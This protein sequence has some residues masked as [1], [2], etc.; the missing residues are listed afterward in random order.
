MPSSKRKTPLRNEPAASGIRQEELNEYERRRLENIKRNNEIL[1][2]LNIPTIKVDLETTGRT[3][4]KIRSSATRFPRRQVEPSRSSMRVRGMNPDGVPIP[5][6]ERSSA[7]T[8]PEPSEE[9]YRE[10]KKGTLNFDEESANFIS[11]VS[12]TT[13][14]EEEKLSAGLK[15]YAKLAVRE[16]D[17]VKTTPDRIYSMAFHPTLPLCCAGDR[18]GHL[19]FINIEHL[20][21]S[22]TLKRESETVHGFHPHVRAITSCL[23]SPTNSNQLLT[24][25]YD[26]SVRIMDIEKQQFLEAF[27][28]PNDGLL[29]CASA[30]REGSFFVSTVDGE[31]G[32]LDPRATPG[33]TRLSRLHERKICTVHLNPV[34][35]HLLVTASLDRTV[36]I[37]DSRKLKSGAW[38]LVRFEHDLAVT[39]ASFSPSGR[40]LLSVSNDNLL[41]LWDPVCEPLAKNPLS[42]TIVDPSKIKHDNRTGRWLTVFRGVWDP[43]DDDI[44]ILGNLGRVVDVYSTK[45]SSHSRAIALASEFMTTVPAVNAC[46]PS[47]NW[48]I[49]GN[50]SGKVFFWRE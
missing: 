20:M 19:G 49:S 22:K 33:S 9:V 39:S 3:P 30:S 50:A 44:F 4:K 46:H 42:D 27:V 1:A 41:R 23:F 7:V 37:W 34:N 38:P 31:V 35:E 18:S 15:G 13:F 48:V 36:G 12:N 14:I 40:K 5:K 32:L 11:A 29:S 6:E 16:S 24:T 47:R 45:A 21:S 17:V 43:K 26:G 8:F 10:R 25:S 2:A 28:H